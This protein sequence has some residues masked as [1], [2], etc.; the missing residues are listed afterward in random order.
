MRMYRQGL[1]LIVRR[2]LIRSGANVTNLN[3]LIAE[4]I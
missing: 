2:E 1:K 3:K 4:A